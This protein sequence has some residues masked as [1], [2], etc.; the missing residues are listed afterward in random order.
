M[1]WL[2]RFPLGIVKAFLA[3]A[4]RL[5]AEESQIEA[6]RAA[7][8][9]GFIPADT[10]RAIERTWAEEAAGHRDAARPTAAGLAG[11]GIGVRGGA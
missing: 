7:M 9:S 6:T 11:I 1:F 4:P 3:M 10:K 5:R 8:G 2:T